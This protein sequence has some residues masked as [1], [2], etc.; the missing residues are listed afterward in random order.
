M[1]RR[2]LSVA[3]V[4]GLYALGLS[5][6]AAPRSSAASAV[7]LPL[8]V[9]DRSVGSPTPTPTA[10]AEPTN[11][12]HSGEGTYYSADG[13]G[14]CSFDPS[15]SNLMVAAMN[16]VDYADS[17]ICGAFIELTGPSG[18]VTVRITD[19]C[20][21]CLVGD[22]DLSQ[23]AFALIADPVAGRV[24]ITWRIVSPELAGPITY[25]FKEGSSQWWTAVQIRNHRNPIRKVEYKNAGGT[26]V[27]LP[28]FSYNYFIAESGM[29]PG[30]Y[31]LRVTDIYGNT[32]TDAGVPL[33][34][35]VD[36]PGGAQFPRGP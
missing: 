14:N 7:H 18:T 11:P 32:L 13:G 34:I 2:L 27:E 24:P 23:Q 6:S 17:A 4:V 19:Q 30:P 9:T 36:L 12:L 15:P 25:R 16:H 31:T 33:T 20:P 8:I 35:G 5:V 10:T 3:C 26:F 29:G 1:V 28:R 22:V 21:E